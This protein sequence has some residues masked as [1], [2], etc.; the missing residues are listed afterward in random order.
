MDHKL[1]SV[2]IL[3]TIKQHFT[4]NELHNLCVCVGG[5]GL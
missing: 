1:D 3:E 2:G 5:G 4:K